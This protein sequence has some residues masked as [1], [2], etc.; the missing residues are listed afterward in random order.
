LANIIRNLRFLELSIACDDVLHSLTF[1]QELGFQA[2]ETNDIWDYPYVVISDGRCYLGL[3]QKE[4]FEQISPITRFAFAHNEV[5]DVI[6]ALADEPHHLAF[7][8]LD[9][10]DKVQHCLFQAPSGFGTHIIAARPFSPLSIPKKSE[11]GYFRAFLLPHNDAKSSTGYWEK[12]GLLLMEDEENVIHISTTD[13][14]VIAGSFP[15]LKEPALLF[16][17]EDPE[18]IFPHLARFGIAVDMPENG[19]PMDGFFCI[20]TPQGIDLIVRK[21]S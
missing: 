17:H 11:L 21:E 13:M 5:E 19:L 1:F 7:Y 8:D 4:H 16:E 20:K 2:I 3:H 10:D 14:H 12:L 15:S 9:S 18:S 6:R